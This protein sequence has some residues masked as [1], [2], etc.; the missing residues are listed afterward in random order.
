MAVKCLVVK[1]DKNIFVFVEIFYVSNVSAQACCKIRGSKSA[2]TTT[3]MFQLH[4]R[5]ALHSMP[6]QSLWNT[7]P[8]TVP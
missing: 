6:S 2:S 5:K 8:I 7:T 1:F 4:T 3:A